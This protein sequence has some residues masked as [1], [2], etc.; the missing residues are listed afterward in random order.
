MED[1]TGGTIKHVRKITDAI[2]HVFVWG[3]YHLLSVSHPS[4]SPP[5]PSAPHSLTLTHAHTCTHSLSLSHS[6][7]ATRS[8]S[9][10][11]KSH[12][13]LTLTRPPT[14]PLTHALTHPRTHSLTHARTHS[15]SSMHKRLQAFFQLLASLCTPS[16]AASR[17]QSVI[18]VQDLP[19]RS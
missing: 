3:S 11:P 1:K 14:Q 12:S 16:V 4:L 19:L 10:S 8:N 15:A 2:S 17:L 9:H 5:P 13:T 7:A 6:L 18:E